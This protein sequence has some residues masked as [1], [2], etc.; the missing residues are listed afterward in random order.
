MP[1]VLV[2]MLLISILLF[3]MHR[4]FLLAVELWKQD[5]S[6][7]PAKFYTNEE[8]RCNLDGNSDDGYIDDEIDAVSM[9]TITDNEV[10][11]RINHLK[12][13]MTMTTVNENRDSK[14]GGDLF[15]LE[16]LINNEREYILWNKVKLIFVTM[17]IVVLSLL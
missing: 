10:R 8:D 6:K 1:N 14:S 2:S 9:S 16:K 15:P 17:G 13:N 3:S 5:V 7:K 4:T 11:N 12:L